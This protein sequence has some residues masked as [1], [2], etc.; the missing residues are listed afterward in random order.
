MNAKSIKLAKRREHLVAQAAA[1]RTA[2][3]QNFEVWRAPL[4]LADQGLA[5]LRFIRRHAV[6]VAGGG[7]LLGVLRPA[8]GSIWKWLRRGWVAWQVARNLRDK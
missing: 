5:V 8:R 6:W 7:I 3:A 1:Q 4:A 2:V